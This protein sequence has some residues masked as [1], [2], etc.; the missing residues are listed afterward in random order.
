MRAIDLERAEP[1]MVLAKTVFAADGRPLLREGSELTDRYLAALRAMRFSYV[2]VVDARVPDIRAKDVISE[3]LRQEA[4]MVIQQ[5]FG[6]PEVAASSRTGMQLQAVANVTKQ[7]VEEILANRDLSIQMADLKS[8]DNYLF[9]HSVNVCVIGTILGHQLGLDEGKLKDL[10]LG[11]MLHDVG[12]MNVPL[13]ILEKPGKLTEPEFE[14]MKEHCRAG[15][16]ALRGAAKFSAHSK[17]VLLQHH[18]KWDGSGYPKGLA[19]DD[20]HVNAQI[21]AIADVYDALTSDRVYRRRYMPHEAIEYLMGSAGS[22]FS[23][24][25]VTTFIGNVAPYPPGTYLK[26]SSGEVAVVV[27]VDMGLA[28]RPVVQ[29]LRDTTG[30]DLGSGGR[31]IQLRREPT[32]MISKVLTD[33]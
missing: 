19:G 18:E 25:L 32:L 28:S 27:E 29:I 13:H 11:L 2:Y 17:I 23:L 24:D 8:H 4:V 7:I 21:C 1:G 10:A 9:A 22:H 30:H 33:A 6:D 15:F 5:T 31:R 20:I 26:L 12:K 16:D 3:E 14:L